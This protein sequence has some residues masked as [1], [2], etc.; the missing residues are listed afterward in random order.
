MSRSDEEIVF[1]ITCSV[2]GSCFEDEPLYR[3][4]PYGEKAVWV[5]YKHLSTGCRRKISKETKE[6]SEAISNV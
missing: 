5:C 6:L 4:N 3:N 2:C 1:G